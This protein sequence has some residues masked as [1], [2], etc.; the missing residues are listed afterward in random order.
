MMP[1]HLP[2]IAFVLVAFTTLGAAQNQAVF[3]SQV[4]TVLLD[5]LV[6][7]RGRPV[8]D[9]RPEDF[10]IRDDGALQQVSHLLPEAASLSVHLLL[11]TSGSLTTRDLDHLRQG[12]SALAK[13]LRRDDSMRL[14]TF[15]RLVQLYDVADAAALDAAFRTLRPSGDTALNDALAAALRLADRPD[16]RRPVV[17]VFSDGADT[18]SWLAARDVDAAA[19]QSWASVFAVT[20]RP[21]G[22]VVLRNITDLT[23]GEV[24]QLGPSLESLPA[25]FLQVFE[26]ARQRYL[27]AFTPTSSAAG[28]H[29]LDVRVRR[30]NLR[31]VT[32]RGY[33]RR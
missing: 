10:V 11:D 13:T 1:Q 30:S 25:T 15:S 12:A 3:R 4:D 20:P 17:I 31:V 23:G 27:V 6:T 14:L 7:D 29:A 16:T 5:V 9:L 24:V 22:L 21:M 2:L 32:R 26:R 8:P 18:A 19:K 33:V 28:W